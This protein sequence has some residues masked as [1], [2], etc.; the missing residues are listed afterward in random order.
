MKQMVYIR[1]ETEKYL[2]VSTPLFFNSMDAINEFEWVLYETHS[3]KKTI[4]VVC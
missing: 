3:D 4:F 2:T 1:D